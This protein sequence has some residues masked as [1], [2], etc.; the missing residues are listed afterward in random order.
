M[1]LPARE[2]ESALVHKLG[3]VRQDRKHRVFALHVKEQRV[4]STM[5][6]HGHQELSDRMLSE[7]A[8]QLGIA[9]RQFIEIVRCTMSRTKY[10]AVLGISDKPDA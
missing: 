8:Q 1:P 10:L 6:S 7:M 5:M 3:F 9:R 2:V 4:A